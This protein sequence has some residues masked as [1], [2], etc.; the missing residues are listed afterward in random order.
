[1]IQ[2]RSRRNKSPSVTGFFCICHIFLYRN[3]TQRHLTRVDQSLGRFQFMRSYTFPRSLGGR[4]VAVTA[5]LGLLVLQPAFSQVQAI[6]GSVRGRVTDPT[7]AP[8]PQAKIDIANND[9]GFLRS[10]ESNDEGYYVSPNL[11]LGSYTVV[12]Q[13]SGFET[14]RHTGIILNAG[15]E[16]VI[17]AGLKIGEVATTREVSGGAPVIQPSRVDTGRTI[18][19]REVDNLPLTSRNPYNF[20]IFQPGV[21]GHPNAELG[22]PRTLN[23]NGQLDRINYQM[24]GMVDTETDRFGLRLFP[25]SDVY[26]REV[27]TVSNSFA[28]EFGNTTGDIYNVIT[29]SGSNQFHGE[30]Y[31]IGRPTDASARTILLGASKPAPDLTLNDNAVN[32]GGRLIKDKLFIFRGYEHLSRGLPQPNTIDP[33]LAAQAGISASLLATAPSVQ[34]AQFLNIRADWVINSKN[35][36]FLRYNYFRNEYPFNTNVGGSF[37]LDAA[38]DFHDRAHIGGVQL[39]TTFSAAMLNELRAS[40]PYRNEAHAADPLTG[41]GPQIVISGVASF[42]GSTN[43]GDRFAEKIPSFNDNF[44]VIRG[45]HTVKTGFGWQENNDN[46]VGDVFSQYTFPT[47]ASYL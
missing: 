34:H 41:P 47:I 16:A 31:F 22:I 10:T 36:L 21:S 27:Q 29:N 11:P 4:L 5:L 8:V 6:N 32:A 1:M 28:P 12:V 43:V 17:D 39:L 13:K 24:D 18:T 14:Q 45:R 20:I 15:T 9:T 42:N 40:E 37:A 2:N 19:T 44:T 30:Y 26:V 3:N 46:Q 7:G 33:T 38:A 23:T 35:Q 25:I